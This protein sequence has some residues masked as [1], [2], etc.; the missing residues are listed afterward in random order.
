M[1]KK[2]ALKSYSNTMRRLKEIIYDGW[3]KNL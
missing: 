1:L 3:L 2:Y